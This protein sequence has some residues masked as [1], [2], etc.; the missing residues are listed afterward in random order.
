MTFQPHTESKSTTKCVACG[1]SLQ[2][3]P[4]SANCPECGSEQRTTKQQGEKGESRLLRMINSNIAV[5]GL[6]PLPDIRVRLK[7]WMKLGAIFAFALFG[8]Q[9]LVTFAL[10]PIGLYRLTLFALSIF[11][12]FVVFGMM[13]NVDASMPPMYTWIRKIAPY[14]QWCW[15]TGYALWLV[16]HVA[17]AD[18]QFT[19]GGNLSLLSSSFFPPILI[20][21]AFA[22]IGLA[23][24]ALWI[25]DLALRLGLDCAAKRSNTFA[26]LV[27]TLGVFVFVLPWKLFAAANLGSVSLIFFGYIVALMAPWLWAVSLF[28]RSML[29]ISNDAT[30]SL[31]YEDG[32]EGRQ[33]RI[34]KKQDE[35]EY[36]RWF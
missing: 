18:E 23:G 22:G 19:I 12:P 29:E 16:F 11:W 2:G 5:T 10:I 17:R 21:H 3:L 32:L 8:L 30:W 9:L 7:Y 20:L 31:I 35:F 26:I 25:H 15:P 27:L 14:S 24:I 4:I 1:Y 33:E 6:A 34:R 36:R 13:P 28:A